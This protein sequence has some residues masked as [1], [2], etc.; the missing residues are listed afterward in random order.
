MI[1]IDLVYDGNT[2]GNYGGVGYLLRASRGKWD[3]GMAAAS[4]SHINSTFIQDDSNS[5]TSFYV[6]GGSHTDGIRL[7]GGSYSGCA[8]KANSF[9]LAGSGI[10]TTSLV[11]SASVATPHLLGYGSTPSV[12]AC[13]GL[14]AGS[15]SMVAGS[16][17]SNGRILLTAGAGAAASGAA[18]LTFASAYGANVAVCN[19]GAANN[20]GGWTAS[21]VLYTSAQS[22]SL[23]TVQWANGAAT[24]L[25]SGSAYI[26]NYICLAH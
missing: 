21:P 11:D 25:S 8:I 4:G 9:C 15:C 26:I 16:T 19:F 5:P 23:V 13:S 6:H 22:Q 3:V 17:D 10:I 14:G 24:A 1:G 12:G 18:T 7:D 2:G 20:T